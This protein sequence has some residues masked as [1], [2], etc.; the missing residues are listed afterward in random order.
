MKSK[1]MNASEAISKIRDNMTLMIGGFNS[2]GDPNEL[3]Q[4]LRTNNQAKNLT[5]INIDAGITGSPL[6][7]MLEDGRFSKVICTFLGANK[8]IG[9]LVNNDLIEYEIVPQGTFAERIRAAGAGL[10]GFLTPTGV[11][12]VVEKDKKKITVDGKEYLLEKPLKAN[13]AIIFAEEADTI[14]NLKMVGT[15]RN[16][17]TVMAMAA[18]YVI[19]QARKVVPVGEILPDQVT[20]PS[21]YVDAVVNMGG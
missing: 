4:F 1:L 14:G 3:I 18:D 5:L 21:I 12:T 9:R 15:A 2:T 19:V 10:G 13:I 7:G 20:V 8:E 16:T 6:T 11:G 17:N